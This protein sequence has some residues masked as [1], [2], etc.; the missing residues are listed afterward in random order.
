MELAK[1]LKQRKELNSILEKNNKLKEEYD[2]KAQ[3]NEDDKILLKSIESKVVDINKENANVNLDLMELNAEI[4]RLEGLEK[5]GAVTGLK[6]NKNNSKKDIFTKSFQVKDY[7]FTNGK[8]I[9][10][11]LKIQ[12]NASYNELKA[13][14]LY[15]KS[16]YEGTTD[17][18]DKYT[19]YRK[20]ANIHTLYSVEDTNAKDGN[21]TAPGYHNNAGETAV[22]V[23][24]MP[25]LL[26]KVIYEKIYGD[27]NISWLSFGIKEMPKNEIIRFVS[28]LTKK[29]KDTFARAEKE[30]E[31]ETSFTSNKALISKK[32]YAGLIN[33][34]EELIR[35]GDDISIGVIKKW[36]SMFA[37]S[38]RRDLDRDAFNGEGKSKL[39]GVLNLDG[40]KQAHLDGKSAKLTTLSP[41][42]ILLDSVEELT[43]L[44]KHYDYDLGSQGSVRTVMSPD[45]FFDAYETSNVGGGYQGVV[46]GNETSFGV[47]NIPGQGE[48][49]LASHV[50]DKGQVGVVN[51]DGGI[52]FY[53]VG[54]ENFLTDGLTD[55][56]TNMHRNE[57]RERQGGWF[58]ITI[59]DKNK[60][61]LIVDN[62]TYFASA[63]ASTGNTNLSADLTKYDNTVA[64][65]G[66]K[67][68]VQ[69]EEGKILGSATSTG[70][71]VT[72]TLTGG[73]TGET[74][75]IQNEKGLT[76][77][78]GVLG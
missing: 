39:L 41:K 28:T 12:E 27:M 2:V 9:H 53:A 75:E 24:Q 3:V 44:K 17:A 66:E 31:T 69:N 62:F 73:V 43:Q 52:N 64:P 19:E 48:V 55:P 58:D 70:G 16:M 34:T 61:I 65:D 68:K 29:D 8:I 57:I 77:G 36:V 14:Q 42:V 59:E 78:T 67:F 45:Y 13:T 63:V 6:V 18:A 25:M 56:Y 74:V 40:R 49:K 21:G 46:A 10:K 30:G 76:V 15:I 33:Y 38:L 37:D 32:S 50:F 26:A 1:L 7:D 4:T 71:K 20:N 11:N 72:F 60:V 47:Y 23:E 54:G 22:P 5:A 51:Y 35:F